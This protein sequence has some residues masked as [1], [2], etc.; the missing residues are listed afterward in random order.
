MKIRL[1]AITGIAFASS[2]ALV[3]PAFAAPTAPPSE[4]ASSGVIR[5]DAPIEV[6]Q[7]S[8]A[9]KVG[10]KLL[11]VNDVT[12]N[13]DLGQAVLSLPTRFQNGFTAQPMTELPKI[14]VQKL[15]A[16]TTSP[17][18]KTVMAMTA[19]DRY[20]E[21]RKADAFNVLVSWPADDP[22]KASVVGSDTRNP[23]ASLELRN[24]LAAAMPAS[25]FFKIEGLA[26]TPD[27]L[28]FGVRETGKETYKDSK[29]GVDIVSIGYSY[30][31]GKLKLNG[32]AT[33]QWSMSAD[34]KKDLKHKDIGVSDLAYSKTTDKVTMTTS[35]EFA[36]T[37]DGVTGYLWT[38]PV[39]ELRPG[40]KAELATTETGAAL[41]FTHKPEG[42]V[43]LSND[44][45]LVIHDDDRRRTNVIAPFGE[46]RERQMAESAFDIVRLK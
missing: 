11:V 5:S 31:D 34:Q 45:T 29:Y 19:F 9:T 28:L 22:S 26:A 43:P 39:S 32:P 37:P 2:A 36:E 18:G 8:G 44:E 40:G 33:K 10:D 23:Q 21:D 27:K 42:V 3:A 35:G 13:K 1:A 12:P 38:I 25:K 4:I 7:L 24:Q 16:I 41:Q 6:S 17:D 20:S 46:L 14:D 30:V 15:E